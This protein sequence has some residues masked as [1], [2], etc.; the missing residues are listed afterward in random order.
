MKMSERARGPRR[1]RAAI[2]FR[3]AGFR[4]A[5]AA[6]FGHLQ[7][8]NEGPP[9]HLLHVGAWW[10]AASATSPITLSTNVAFEQDPGSVGWGQ[11]NLGLGLGPEPGTGPGPGVG[12]RV[13]KILLRPAAGDPAI[14]AANLK[15]GQPDSEVSQ[16]DLAGLSG[17]GLGPTRFGR[18]RRIRIRTSPIRRASPD[19][20]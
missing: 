12:S 19:S 18:P 16:P 2:G 10:V 13:R 6:P 9:N 3:A 5:A 4:A 8:G 20:D 17:F 14:G 11:W 7:G 15:A 1:G